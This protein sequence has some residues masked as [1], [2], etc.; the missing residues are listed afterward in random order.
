MNTNTDPRKNYYIAS[1]KKLIEKHPIDIINDLHARNAIV[2]DARKGGL[3]IGASHEDGGIIMLREAYC[4]DRRVLFPVG[5]MQGGEFL[6][7]P[8]ATEKYNGRLLEI[9]SFNEYFD[10]KDIAL[11]GDYRVST[12]KIEKGYA[13]LISNFAQ[14]V[15]NRNATL[16]YLHELNELNRQ[17]LM[18]SPDTILPFGYKDFM[19]L[20][21]E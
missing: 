14:M 19:L 4:G 20:D 16:C 17:P 15:I 8:G 21:N 10:A 6:V 18:E 11:P 7:N 3:I 5:E 12:F 2:I 1:D 9:N 13:I